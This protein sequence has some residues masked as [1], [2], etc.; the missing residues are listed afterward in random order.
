VDAE[1]FEEES[2]WRHR[3]EEEYLRYHHEF[4]QRGRRIP[5]PGWRSEY[6]EEIRQ[7]GYDT[8]LGD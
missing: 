5:A 2:Q 6:A 7:L 1:V 8:L 3:L 4:R